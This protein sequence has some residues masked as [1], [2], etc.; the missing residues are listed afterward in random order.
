[1]MH[2]VLHIEDPSISGAMLEV[3]LD[4]LD[5]VFQTNVVSVVRVIQVCIALLLMSYVDFSIPL[6]RS[7]SHDIQ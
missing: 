7:P 5:R 6:G 2:I 1:M 3:S 4:D